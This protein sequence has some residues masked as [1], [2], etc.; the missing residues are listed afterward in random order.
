MIGFSLPVQ[1]WVDDDDEARH[2][3]AIISLD[4]DVDPPVLDVRTADGSV[5]INAKTRDADEA[6]SEIRHQVYALEREKKEQARA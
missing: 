4:I 3:T 1:V 6:L 2:L 5:V